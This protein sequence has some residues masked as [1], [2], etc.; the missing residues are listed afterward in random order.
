[1]E[2]QIPEIISA[3]VAYKSCTACYGYLQTKVGVM[4]NYA[5]L[6]IKYDLMLG[7]L[8]ALKCLMEDNEEV[9]LEAATACMGCNGKDAGIANVLVENYPPMQRILGL[10]EEDDN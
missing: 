10:P 1:M 7:A 3:I 9:A 2:E 4:H 8:A 5:L 6:R